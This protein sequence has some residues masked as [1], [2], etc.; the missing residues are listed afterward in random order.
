[1]REG[2]EET[3]EGTRT[4]QYASNS[5]AMGKEREQGDNDKTLKVKTG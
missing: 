2:D 4:Q 3:N 5:A 1:M